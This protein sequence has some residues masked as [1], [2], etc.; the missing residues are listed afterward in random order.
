MAAAAITGA[1][2]WVG[3]GQALQQLERRGTSDLALASDR[4]VR[5]LSRYRELVVVL[6]G[7]PRFQDSSVS[8]EALNGVLLRAAD[9]SGALDLLLLDAE[10]G[11]RASASG[12]PIDQWVREP[13]IARALTG[14]LGKFH[15]VSEAFGVRSFYF[16]APIFSP[17]GPVVG[18][19]VAVVDMDR[20][21]AEGR[22]E[23]PAVLFTD[24][25]GVT[26]SSNRSELVMMQRGDRL[27]DNTARFGDTQLRPFVPFKPQMTRGVPL[28]SIEAGPYVPERAIHVSRDIFLLDLR[29]E[30]LVD[31]RPAYV[32]AG[33]QA[34]A[35]AAL[36]MVFGALLL[37]AGERR[38]VLSQAN[39]ALEGRVADRTAELSRMNDTL[40]DEVAE[41]R[42]AEAALKRAQDELV[43]VGKLSA[44][45]QMS[46][47]ISHEL[48]QPLMAIRTFAE[49]GTRFL[50]R[51][52]GEKVRG[53]LAKISDLAGRMARIIKNLK[54][55]ARQESE[56]LSKVELGSIAEAA[57]EVTETHLSREGV[58]LNLSLPEGPV[59]VEGG[60]VRLQQVLVNLITNA[61]DAMSSSDRPKVIDLFVIQD[62]EPAFVVKDSGPGIDD[63]DRIF[64]P[65]YSTK[66]VG[67]G[68]G[69]GLG[70]SI[71]Y[72]LV[73]SFGGNIS[74]ENAPDGGAVF[75]VR[76]KPWDKDKAA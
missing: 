63:V 75:T 53:N 33:L 16:A 30:A 71:S 39:A 55:F 57:A 21:E 56:P 51:S 36:L 58:A 32:T 34:T 7:D 52:D 1:V 17:Q 74:G 68:E 10:R 25:L 2:W 13:F 20:L 66:S 19:L 8:T 45:G 64:E 28:W 50:E 72:G 12:E 41:R 43:Q 60:E 59:W 26:F 5:Q 62:P 47:G 23:T 49:N 6:S 54:A 70:L 4:L 27:H 35:V 22:G 29:A 37:L 40:R 31:A 61:A 14:G 38:R 11:L 42:E 48:N 3:L 69:T 18:V 67:D 46:A 76:L 44:L 65:F 73:Q 24:T 15:A 9:M